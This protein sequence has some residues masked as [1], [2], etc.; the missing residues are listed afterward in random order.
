MMSLGWVLAQLLQPTFLAMDQSMTCM[1]APTLLRY[2]TFAPTREMPHFAAK[3]DTVSPFDLYTCA[4]CDN[5]FILQ[6][7]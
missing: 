5:L 2:P 1:S 7:I 6:S 3:L 4:R